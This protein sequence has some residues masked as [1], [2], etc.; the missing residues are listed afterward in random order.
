MRDIMVDLE[1]TGIGPDRTAVIQIAAVKFDLETQEVE[2]TFFDRCMRI[3]PH[4]SW[5]EDTR[6]WW[7]KQKR[8]IIEGIFRRMED[9][10]EVMEDFVDWCYPRGSLRLWAKPSHFEYPFIES[11]CRDLGLINP[12]H[13]REV[14]DLN[15]FLRGKYYPEPVAEIDVPFSGDAHNALHDTLHQI[16][17]LFTHMGEP[18]VIAG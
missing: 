7:L 2:S 17:I 5:Q 16:K 8:S 14:T 12:F 15:S 1:T 11:Y 9:P 3:P 6:D 18:H 4:R 13:Y 10:R